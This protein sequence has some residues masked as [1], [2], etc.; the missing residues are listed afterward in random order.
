MITKKDKEAAK[1][2]Y[3]E[4]IEGEPLTHETPIDCYLAACELKNKEIEKYKKFTKGLL[5][6]FDFVKWIGK[7]D[8]KSAS[9]GWYKVDNGGNTNFKSE[10]ELYEIFLKEEKRGKSK[11]STRKTK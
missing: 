2:Y 11:K 4:N 9:S 7:N 1:L 10:T 6:I 3:K 5:N 8:W